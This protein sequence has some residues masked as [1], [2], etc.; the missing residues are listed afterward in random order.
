[1]TYGRIAENVVAAAQA[2]PDSAVCVL[3][4]I[5]P[6]PDDDEFK[7]LVNSA[8]RLIF[9]EESA[10]AGGIGEHFAACEWVKP[11]VEIKAIEDTM[12]PH[13][14]LK[15]LMEYAGL[16]VESIKNFIE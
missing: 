12:I 16:D 3:R 13:G 14:D 6:L 8:E 15:Y 2:K 11:K 10:R 5:F 4:R 7:A 1:M 9:V